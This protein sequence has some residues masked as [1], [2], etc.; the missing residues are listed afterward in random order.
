MAGFSSAETTKT[1]L[2]K[3]IL[4]AA[5]SPRVESPSKCAGRAMTRALSPH[6]S[7]GSGSVWHQSTCCW[8]VGGEFVKRE[9]EREK[10]FEQIHSSWVAGA[11][12]EDVLCAVSAA[13]GPADMADSADSTV[14]VSRIPR[15]LCF[16]YIDIDSL[17]LVQIEETHKERK[18]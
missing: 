16:S 4:T 7:A 15:L 9:R 10:E 12:G 18:E 2:R 13:C 8:G 14:S 1:W 6:A 3:K 17:Y 5:L 11:P